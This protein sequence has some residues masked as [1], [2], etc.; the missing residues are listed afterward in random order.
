MIVKSPPLRFLPD[1]QMPL[2]DALR[3]VASFAGAAEDK[4]RPAAQHLPERLRSRF[5]RALKSIERAGK[6]LI[7]SPIGLDQIETAS[8]FLLGAKTSKEAAEICATVFVY[9]WEHLNQASLN[10]RHLIS[11]TIVA[12]RL[13]RTRCTSR[14]IGA[15]FAATA[16]ADIRGS[17]AIGLIPGLAREVSGEEKAESDLALLAIAVWLL[18]HRAEMLENEENLLELSMALVG[19]L[20]SEAPTVF[21]DRL[22]LARFLSNSSAH[23]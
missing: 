3:G 12:D 16:L 18:S 22:R 17:T 13:A 19:A 1:L 20:Q 4:L 6:R 8:Q 7:H 14:L 21:D 2:R 23:L 15:E 11:E 10:H 5:R 9:A